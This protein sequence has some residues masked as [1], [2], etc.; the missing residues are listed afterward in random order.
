MIVSLL[1]V[2]Q[3]SQLSLRLTQNGSQRSCSLR[4]HRFV[5]PSSTSFLTSCQ[6]SSRRTTRCVHIG[7]CPLLHFY[8]WTSPLRCPLPSFPQAVIEPLFNKAI[9]PYVHSLSSYSVLF[10]VAVLMADALSAIAFCVFTAPLTLMF[11]L[12]GTLV[13]RARKA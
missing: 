10:S 2:T 12:V 11:C 1:H 9:F 6:T 7:V 3:A 13:V 4:R 5:F 8:L